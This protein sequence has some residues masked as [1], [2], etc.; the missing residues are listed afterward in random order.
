MSAE[1]G[2]PHFQE[3]VVRPDEARDV[4]PVEMRSDIDAYRKGIEQIFIEQFGVPEIPKE[5][6]VEI[7]SVLHRIGGVVQERGF[8]DEIDDIFSE[9]LRTIAVKLCAYRDEP[10]DI[11]VESIPE[12]GYRLSYKTKTGEVVLRMMTLEEQDV[13][14][15]L[16]LLADQ[17]NQLRNVQEF[18]S[19]VSRAHTAEHDPEIVFRDV[20]HAYRDFGFSQT[21][22]RELMTLIDTQA[23]F[24]LTPDGKPP[25]MHK[26]EVMRDVWDAYL[27]SPEK[28]KYVKFAVSMIAVGATEGIAPLFLKH[29]MDSDV[30]E[31]AALFG[32]GYLGSQAATGWVRNMLSM[33]FD[34]FV[35]TILGKPGGLNERLANDLVF[36]PGEKMAE[37]DERGRLLTSARRSQEAFR[38]ILGSVAKTVAPAIASATVGAGML[39]GS[40]WRLGLIALA[41]A[42]IA[43]ILARRSEKAMRPLIKQ[44]YESEDKMAFEVEEQVGAHMEIVLSGM[45]D[46]MAPRLATLSARANELQH[47]RARVRGSFDFR[48]GSVLGPAVTSGLVL[49]GVALRRL[50]VPNAGNIV[51]SIVYASKFRDSFDSIVNQQQE[52]LQSCSSIIEMEEIFNGYAAEETEKDRHRT[53]ASTLSHFGI[54]LN[55]V[56]LSIGEKQIINDINIAI[57]SG[58]VAR[59]EGVTG[60]GKTT[61]MKIIAGYYHPTEGEVLVGSKRVDDIKQTGDDSFYEHVSYLSQFPYVFDSGSIGENLRFGNRDVKD[62]DMRG[63]LTELHLSERF[64]DSSIIN[65]DSK[66]LGLSGGERRRL[67]LA[68][69]ILKIRS[70]EKGG[71]VFLDEPTEGLDEETE[72]EVAEILSREKSAH[73]NITFIIVTHRKTFIDTFAKARNGE[74]GHVVQRIRLK[75]GQIA[76]IAPEQL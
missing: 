17:S 25:G 64:S 2:T 19:V 13:L 48:I 21:Q 37:T 1:F 45:R 68:R 61:L 59:I 14:C 63:V 57:P 32:A 36:Q 9:K 74:D 18:S 23:I 66:V 20:Y 51:S 24:E 44:T 42:P 27:S 46:A 56:S 58:S 60:H 72:N 34:L 5:V 10:T 28:S 67:G 50:G 49:A 73:P 31:T 22:V 69:V 35:N 71:I 75:R 6:V 30:M 47:D 4:F 54:K 55:N 33:K 65:L 43:V 52:M 3:F 12:E 41:S 40:D 15:N 29:L 8:V 53:G 16:E 38:E 76:P 39:L 11:L 62:D 7:D 26:L 70:Q